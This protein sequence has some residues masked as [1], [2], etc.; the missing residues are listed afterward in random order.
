LD[1]LS[2]SIQFLEILICFSVAA[3]SLVQRVDQ[4]RTFEDCRRHMDRGLIL[5][6]PL[7]LHRCFFF[8][9]SGSAQRVDC[10]FPSVREISGQKDDID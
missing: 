7:K 1:L 9:G 3:K 4:V 2:V 5:M 8:R 10:G 6:E